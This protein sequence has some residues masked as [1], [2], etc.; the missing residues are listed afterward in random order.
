MSP[1]RS[2]SGRSSTP[3]FERRSGPGPV[4]V[5]GAD[6]VVAAGGDEQQAWLVGGRQPFEHAAGVVERLGVVDQ[7]QRQ[8][9]GARGCVHQRHELV[10]DGSRGAT[11]SSIDASRAAKGE[12]GP[13]TAI[14]VTSGRLARQAAATVSR[15]V[16]L[17]D[18]AGPVTRACSPS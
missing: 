18:R 13:A 12:R 8:P 10:A 9:T 4:G 6:A 5:T 11:I 17:P 14:T 3:S 15:V 1:S 7:H 16:L 2:T